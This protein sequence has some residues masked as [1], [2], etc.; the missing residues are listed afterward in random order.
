V[1]VEQVQQLL[2]SFYARK[3]RR[4]IIVA[5]VLAHDPARLV[6]RRLLTVEL[7]TGGRCAR[8]RP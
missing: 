2:G 8:E 1:N 7:V 6:R 4:L 3:L 5:L